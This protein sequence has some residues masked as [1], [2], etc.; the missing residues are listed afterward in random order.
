[1]ESDRKQEFDKQSA[2][3]MDH[4]VRSIQPRLI[5]EK[6]KKP[7]HDRGLRDY[8]SLHFPIFIRSNHVL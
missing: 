1:M 6:E 4:V 3:L 2:F 5:Q 8:I 7:R